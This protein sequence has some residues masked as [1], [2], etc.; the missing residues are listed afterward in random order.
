MDAQALRAKVVG[1]AGPELADAAA[2]R[3]R[4]AAELIALAQL[5]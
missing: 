4:P 1:L 3:E 5:S 2:D